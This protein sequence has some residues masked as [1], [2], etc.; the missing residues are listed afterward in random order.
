M[1]LNLKKSK[2]T[3]KE[4]IIHCAATP[5]G[6]DFTVD[7]IRKWHLAQG[8]NDIG[9]HYV[10]GRHGELWEGRP[11]DNIGAHCVNHNRY[12][13]GVCYVGGVAK[14]GKTPK[15]TRT[16]QQ[17]AQLLLLLKELRKLYPNAKIYGHRNFSKKACPSFDAMSEY[18]SI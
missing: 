13:I 14:D 9:Y 4:I 11:V 18:S 12:S 15:D 16:L 1:E 8:W 7:D 2:R 5:E 17:K 3:I 6:K 10:I